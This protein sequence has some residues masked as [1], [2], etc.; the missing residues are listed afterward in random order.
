M[1]YII[2]WLFSTLSGGW[3]WIVGLGAAPAIFQFAI[4]FILPETPRW[5]VQ[6]GREDEAQSVLGKIYRSHS[7]G[8]SAFA[9]RVLRDIQQEVAEE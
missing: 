8:D 6:A 4:L 2:G 7:G 3:R 5:L 1:A 9:K